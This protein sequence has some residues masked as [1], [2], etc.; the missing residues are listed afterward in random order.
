MMRQRGIFM[1]IHEQVHR[2]VLSSLSA[3]P[4]EATLNNTLRLLAKYRSTLI[5]N[6]LVSRHGVRV[7]SGPF[8]GMEFIEQSIEGCHVP[9]LLG[10]YEAE[11]HGFLE[12][13]PSAGY[14]NVVNIGCAEGYYAVGLKRLMPHARIVAYDINP[15]ALTVCRSVA[16]KN[17]VEIDIRQEFKPDDLQ[18][19]AGSRTLIWCDIEGAEIDVIDPVRTPAM[20]DMDIVVELHATKRGHARDIVPERFA[21]SHSLE[22]IPNESHKAQLP[23]FIKNL[24]HLDQLLAQWEWR[25]SPTPWAIMQARRPRS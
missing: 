16:E 12:T 4:A 19:F 14:A 9:K 1:N 25:S 8:A 20:L 24:G 13:L 5:T 22:I 15:R 23:E 21:Q 10:C 2:A 18:K 17:G 3:G 7:M 6:T 11:L